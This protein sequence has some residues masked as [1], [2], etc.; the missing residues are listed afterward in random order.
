MPFQL[1]IRSEFVSLKYFNGSLWQTESRKI[2]L[3]FF[4]SR[5]SSLPPVIKLGV[6]LIVYRMQYA[7]KFRLRF[8]LHC[9]ASS[10]CWI[11]AYIQSFYKGFFLS[12]SQ[13]PPNDDGHPI[14][15]TQ[16]WSKQWHPINSLITCF[17]VL[18]PNKNPEIWKYANPESV[19]KKL[20]VKEKCFFFIW[21]SKE[22][23]SEFSS[24]LDIKYYQLH[25]L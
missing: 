25:N 21:L 20:N 14:W 4:R 12:Q 15:R 13:F 18:L 19:N 1:N 17:S 23:C 3:A 2:Y 8:L 22:N 9:E 5:E 10:D 16:S 11:P 24:S 6:L 7:C